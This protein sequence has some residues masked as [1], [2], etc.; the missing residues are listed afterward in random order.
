[1]NFTSTLFLFLFF[2]IFLIIYFLLPNIRLK[3]IFLLIASL[4]FYSTGEPIFVY[5]MIISIIVNYFIA[6]NIH[7]TRDKAKQKK[8]LIISIILN[9]GLLAFFKYTNFLIAT[10]NSLFLANISL[11]NI[12]LPIG[13][14][15][16]TFQTMSYVFDVY[17]DDA[18]NDSIHYQKNILDFALYI[19]M[20]PQL[21]AGPIVR[22]SN[23]SKEIKSRKFNLND[24]NDG[25]KRF[26]YGLSKKVLIANSMAIVADRAFMLDPKDAGFAMLTLGAISYTLQIYFDFS[27]Y[28]DMAI[29]IG[30]M[31]GFHFPENF[32]NPYLAKSVTDFWRRWHITLSSWFKDYLY[33]PLGGSKKGFNKTIINLLIVWVL[34][35]LW[36]GAKWTFVLWGLLY[37][38]FLTFEKHFKATH[39]NKSI[40][41]ILPYFLCRIYTMVVIVL[42]WV[43]FRSDSIRSAFLYI[44]NMFNITNRGLVNSQSL[45]YIKDFLLIY[46]FAILSCTNFFKILPKIIFKNPEKSYVYNIFSIIVIII[47][48]ILCTLY[49]IKGSYNPFIY[50]NF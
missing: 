12:P 40:D 9:I 25:L 26:V 27:G 16:F 44:A 1:M 15:F 20:F 32:K 30:K 4:Y 31:I 5:A 42:L 21:V 10:I 47:L 11:I 45:F 35:G 17:Y 23:I 3:N 7:S 19:S 29:G 34:T 8:L 41:R 39:N 46:I 13:I 14:S 18:R 6:K 2:P 28:S 43:I 33:I 38:V 24:I 50:F 36:H 48:L 49:I 22:Y 37:F